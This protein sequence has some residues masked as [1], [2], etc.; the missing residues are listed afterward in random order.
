MSPKKII[1]TI[2]LYCSLLLSF[3]LNAQDVCQHVSGAKVI[4]D[5]GKFLGIIASQYSTDSIFN[6][7]GSHG[8]EYSSDSIWNEYGS[9]GGKYSSNSPFNDYTSSAPLIIKDNRVIGRLTTNKHLQNA[10]NPYI[11]KSCDF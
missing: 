2:F 7:Y 8:S 6:E 4:A 10:I 3:C 5:D 11:L 9:Y 1:N